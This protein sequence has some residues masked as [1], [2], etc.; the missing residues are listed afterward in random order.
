MS[1]V[2]QLEAEHHPLGDEFAGASDEREVAE[3]LASAARLEHEQKSAACTYMTVV[4]DLRVQVAC[5]LSCGVIGP[6]CEVIGYRRSTWQLPSQVERLQCDAESDT[7]A[8]A[9]DLG[10]LAGV[11]AGAVPRTRQRG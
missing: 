3:M 10:V 5:A 1:L 9:S 11:Q 6:C 4:P 8:D 2:L 7:G